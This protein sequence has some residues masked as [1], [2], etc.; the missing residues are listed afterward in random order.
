MFGC[1]D[2]SMKNVLESFSGE[3]DT[4]VLQARPWDYINAG[5]LSDNELVITTI[6]R[7]PKVWQSHT[8]I[9]WNIHAM[10]AIP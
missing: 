1:Y 6:S 2:V 7:N 3:G 10:V 9:S 5:N 8:L 4:F